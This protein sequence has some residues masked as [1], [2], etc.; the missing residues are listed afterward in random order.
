MVTPLIKNAY[1]LSD[2]QMLQ[3]INFN[4]I[5]DKKQLY[6]ETRHGTYIITYITNEERLK[7]QHSIYMYI[8]IQMIILLNK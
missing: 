3:N 7:M 2:C 1:R 5:E 6:K 8:Y 4:N